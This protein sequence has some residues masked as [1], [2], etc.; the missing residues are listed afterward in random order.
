MILSFFG[1]GNQAAWG[2]KLTVT[3]SFYVKSLELGNHSATRVP[4]S[5]KFEGRAGSLDAPHCKGKILPYIL[6]FPSTSAAEA[7]K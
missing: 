3:I 2:T 4:H 5:C 7:N 6:H 1:A